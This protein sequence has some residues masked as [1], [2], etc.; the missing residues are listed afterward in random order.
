MAMVAQSPICACALV[1]LGPHDPLAVR[2]GLENE[3]EMEHPARELT[4]LYH[5]RWEHEIYYRELK[6]TLRKHK[7]L[8][9]QLL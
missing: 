6:Q 3:Q 1:E 4:D 5:K 9:G 7:Y 2:V 8:D